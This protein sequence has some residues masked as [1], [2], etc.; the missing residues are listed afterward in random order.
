MTKIV[1]KWQSQKI[2]VEKIFLVGIDSECFETYF[3]TKISKSK[4]FSR[5]KFFSWD[6]VFSSKMTK[7]VKKWQSKKIWSKFFC[8]SRL[9]MFQKSFAVRIDHRASRAYYIFLAPKQHTRLR[10]PAGSCLIFC[11]GLGHFFAKS[12]AP[13]KFS[14]FWRRSRGE[15]P[16]IVAL[17]LKDGFV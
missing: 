15:Y 3:K 10:R 14:W 16:V 5:V 8:R 2:L 9:W 11:L 7:I 17:C 12:P 6:F 13:K 1:K 4:I